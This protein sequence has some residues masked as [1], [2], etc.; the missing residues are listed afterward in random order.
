[1]KRVRTLLVLLAASLLVTTC[2]WPAMAELN[3]PADKNSAGYVTPPAPPGVPQGVAAS[4][5]N[6]Q[7]TISWSA[8]NA[9]TSYNLYYS[10]V[11]GVT[12]ST[13][14]RI[15]GVSSPYT[16]T[17]LA[18]GT[19]FYFVVIAV[20]NGIE[21][22]PSAEANATTSGSYLSLTPVLGPGGAT[23]SPTGV[24][25]FLSGTPV[26]LSTTALA[27]YVFVGWNVTSG[28]Y[29]SFS[30]IN[31][32]STTITVS[33]S[34]ATVEAMFDPV[35]TSVAGNGNQGFSGDGGRATLAQINCPSYVAAD[36]LGNFFFFDTNNYRIRRVDAST[37]TITTVAGNGTTG[38]SGDGGQA[39]SAGIGVDCRVRVDATGN[40]YLLQSGDNG[41]NWIRKVNG[42][43]G[44]IT[45]VAGNGTS[46]FSGD[47]GLATLAQFS[48]PLDF[49]VEA[50]GNLY[51]A[52]GTRIR[53]VT[54]STGI[55]TTVAGNG[56]SG[57][58]ADGG[59]ATSTAIGGTSSVAVDSAGNLYFVAGYWSSGYVQDSIYHLF[60]VS[61]STGVITSIAGGQPWGGTLIPNGEL[62]STVWLGPVSGIDVDAGGNIYLSEIGGV[63]SVSKIAASTGIITLVAGGFYQ[64]YAGDGGRAKTALLS[65]VKGIA[66]DGFGN[67]YISDLANQ[68]IRKVVGQGAGVGP[69]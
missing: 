33:T 22:R 14:T 17:S 10:T 3:N 15:I 4:A 18:N 61:H 2:Q 7:V 46:G 44:I 16:V 57:F 28:T 38:F 37:G 60:K 34:N 26:A 51:I 19:K 56:S 64:G 42:S 12:A 39:I 36:D 69:W 25:T 47:G 58:S 23:I 20:K 41:A 54:A 65:L 55:V 27:G 30:N 35:I 59:L 48:G 49:A 11:A 50:S 8:V 5:G 43:T 32:S 62:G 24:T 66:L 6:G 52:D 67:L 9:A 68:R 1:M 21:S 40:L 13:G 31:N 45:T 63:P 29:D 53:K